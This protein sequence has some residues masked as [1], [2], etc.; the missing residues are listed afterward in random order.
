[1]IFQNTLEDLVNTLK[2]KHKICSFSEINDSILIWSHY[3]DYHKGFC[4]EYSFTD[5]PCDNQL[6]KYIFPVI[7]SPKLYNIT[8]CM[9]NSPKSNYNILSRLLLYLRKSEEWKYQKEWRLVTLSENPY[10]YKMPTPTA[11]YFGA[12]IT[13]KDK[14]LLLDI[15]SKK[16]IKNYY[17]SLSTT[18]FKMTAIQD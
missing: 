4:T 18:E 15:T 13:D 16:N 2:S 7:Y 8:P 11:I 12:K 3:A 9:I 17:M 6:S 14:N 10:S 1:M 5:L